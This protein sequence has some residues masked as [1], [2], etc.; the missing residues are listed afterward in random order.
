M[1]RYS[2]RARQAV[3]FFSHLFALFS[4]PFVVSFCFYSGAVICCFS[5]F[6]FDLLYRGNVGRNGRHVAAVATWAAG[7]V[8][9]VREA[10]TG[11]REGARV[12][13]GKLYKK[14]RGTDYGL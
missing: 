7:L 2:S 10:E 1:L 8:G 9:E 3:D 14:G 6:Y 4:T 11:K 13:R 5:T 12:S